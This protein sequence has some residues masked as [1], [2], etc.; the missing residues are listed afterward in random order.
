MDWEEIAS[1]AIP[2]LGVGAQ[3]FLAGNGALTGTLVAYSFPVRKLKA[4]TIEELEAAFSL[5]RRVA[6][7][8]T[9]SPQSAG[10]VP[11]P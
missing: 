4:C 11:R 1:I 7:A 3:E 5:V 8:A 2:V 6:A 9:P 10:R